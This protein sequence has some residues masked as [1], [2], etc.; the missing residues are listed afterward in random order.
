MAGSTRLAICDE[1]STVFDVE[2]ADPPEG[3]PCDSPTA[4]P[5]PAPAARIAVAVRPSI[6]RPRCRFGGSGA[7]YI[8]YCPYGY[9]A[10]GSLIGPATP[11]SVR[12]P[13]SSYTRSIGRKP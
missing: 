6:V 13:A 5:A 11:N 7:W 9:C 12:G 3:D 2:V 1:D 4:T 8:P 10:N